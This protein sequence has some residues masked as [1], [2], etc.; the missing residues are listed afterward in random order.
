MSEITA[1]HVEVAGLLVQGE[2]RQVHRAAA[3]EGGPTTM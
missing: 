2:P 1:G 3:E